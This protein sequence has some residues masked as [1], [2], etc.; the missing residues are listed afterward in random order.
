[1]N[2]DRHT[3]GDPQGTILDGGGQILMVVRGAQA[4]GCCA[5]QRIDETT[6]ELAKMTIE[7]EQRGGLDLTQFYE[8]PSQGPT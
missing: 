5:L 6:L 4:I 8:R 7:E 1:M 3:L 2:E